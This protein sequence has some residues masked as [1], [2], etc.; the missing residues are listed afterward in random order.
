[1]EVEKAIELMQR[2]FS[3][4]RRQASAVVFTEVMDKTPGDIDMESLARVIKMMFA[5]L[6]KEQWP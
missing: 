6:N 3:I 4:S 1:M 5:S 2:L